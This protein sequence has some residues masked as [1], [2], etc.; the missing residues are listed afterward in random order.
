MNG[1]ITL[2]YQL[3]RYVAAEEINLVCAIIE[4]RKRYI[5]NIMKVPWRAH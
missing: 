3:S 5:N 2:Q 1:E 4:I